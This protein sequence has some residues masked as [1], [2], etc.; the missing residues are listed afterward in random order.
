MTKVKRSL[1][2][3]LTVEE[4]AKRAKASKGTIIKM[5]RSGFYKG[6]RSFKGRYMVPLKEALKE[7]KG[8]HGSR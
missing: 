2:A 8:A 4:V 7:L 6:V 3:Y 5:I 1:V